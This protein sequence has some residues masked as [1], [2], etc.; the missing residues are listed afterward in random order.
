[1]QVTPTSFT[2][3]QYCQQMA[4]GT[5]LI[6][7]DYQRSPKAWPPKARSYLID[8]ILSGYPIPKISLYQKTD[9]RS[10]KTIYEIVDGQQRSSAIRDFYDGKL[11]LVGKG[12][13]AGRTYELLDDE[14]KEKF[15][16]YQ[17][18]VDLFV[19]A[20]PQEIR[21]VFRRINSY[22][23]PLNPQEHRHAIHQGEFKW[24]VADLCRKYDEALVS[25]GVMTE[26]GISRMKDGE[27]F[28]E[29]THAVLH[30]IQSANQS[31]LGALYKEHDDVFP[32]GP[33]MARRF[34]SAFND[35]LALE[36]IRQTALLK[37]YNFYS[38]MLAAMHI[39]EPCPTLQALYP[40][41]RRRTVDPLLA[42]PQLM[43]MLSAV[44]NKVQHGPYA[45]YVAACEKGTNRLAQREVRFRTFCHALLGLDP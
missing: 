37:Q 25:L 30:G 8:T 38:L 35:A 39:A 36:S 22:T 14:G 7:T 33:E 42:I 2:V 40:I 19:S 24:F 26:S 18:S 1:M 10:K 21:E 44:D 43:G 15:L 16:S 12:D 45:G 6:N 27:L 4:A 11:K 3:A 28:T 20:A 5:V 9:V 41:G 34:E 29:I 17:I 31:S 23:V 32:Q 13:Y